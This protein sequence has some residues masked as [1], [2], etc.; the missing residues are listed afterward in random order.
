MQK[1]KRIIIATL[2]GTLF[3]FVCF[4]IA[5]SSP[6]VLPLAIAMQLILSRALIGFAIGIS[7][8]PMGHWSIHG[9][10]MGLIFSLPLAF[11]SMMASGNPA[12]TKA[13]MFIMTNLMGMVY[14]VLTELI[15]TV[16]FK[17]KMQS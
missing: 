2:A 14:G 1:S 10:V 12:F 6:G 7:S 4:G 3:G 17:A 5:S 8:V 16:F 15:T 13:S 11:G 9:L